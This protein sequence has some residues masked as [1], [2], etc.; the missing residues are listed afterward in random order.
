MQRDRVDERVDGQKRRKLEA[1]TGDG[2]EASASPRSSTSNGRT[3]STPAPSVYCIPVEQDLSIASKLELIKRFC[4]VKY[5]SAPSRYRS[6]SW[7]GMDSSTESTSTGRTRLPTFPFLP[8]LAP[9]PDDIID[10]DVWKQAEGNYDK[11]SWKQT[12]KALGIKFSE[13][14]SSDEEESPPKPDPKQKQERY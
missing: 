10:N 14:S 8:W 9:V 5:A 11:F 13:S 4:P 3:S 2:G 7:A 1:K 6:M 12:E